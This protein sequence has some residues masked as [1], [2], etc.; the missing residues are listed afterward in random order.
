MFA[1]ADVCGPESVHTIDERYAKIQ[2][3]LQELADEVG[4]SVFE[5]SCLQTDL[6]WLESRRTQIREALE[7]TPPPQPQ[8]DVMPRG[9]AGR[10]SQTLQIKGDMVVGKHIAKSR[11]YYDSVQIRQ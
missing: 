6:Q 1:L 10:K 8:A 5:G 3:V 2:A 7:C 4:S 11:G 9:R